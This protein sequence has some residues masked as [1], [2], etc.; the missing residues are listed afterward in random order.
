MTMNEKV[1]LPVAAALPVTVNEPAACVVPSRNV[2]VASALSNVTKILLFA[3]TVELVTVQLEAAAAIEARPEG[4]LIVV[5][6][7][8]AELFVKPCVSEPPAPDVATPT[9]RS[10]IYAPSPKMTRMF[11]PDAAPITESCAMPAGRVNV[12]TVE[13]SMYTPFPR[14]SPGCAP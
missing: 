2:S 7:G 13:G 6:P 9:A 4:V 8:T 14:V 1:Q 5:L 12:S 11:E 3:V 10:A